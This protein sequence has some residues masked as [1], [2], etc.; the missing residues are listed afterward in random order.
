[1]SI[2][3]ASN[4]ELN[5][6]CRLLRRLSNLLFSSVS[7]GSYD[8]GGFLIDLF[9]IRSVE[10]SRRMTT[11]DVYKGSILLFL[12]L[13]SMPL[14][15]FRVSIVLCYFWAVSIEE[16]VSFNSLI[17]CSIGQQGFSWVSWIGKL[18]DLRKCEEGLF[19]SWENEVIE[20]S[21]WESR[22]ADL[23]AALALG[24]RTG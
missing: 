21:C 9:M 23:L 1:M 20:S 7:L 8:K 13:S 14:I 4:I 19:R 10:R 6:F 2:C 22:M 3:L 24:E 15:A 18:L 11:V 17:N 12:R 16:A 5:S